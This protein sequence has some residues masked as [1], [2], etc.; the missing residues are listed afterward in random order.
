[1]KSTTKGWV[2]AISVGLLWGAEAALATL[3]LQIIDARLLVW[4]RYMMAF[5][6]LSLVLVLGAM[7]QHQCQMKPKLMFNWANRNDLFK[8]FV[9]GVFGQGL[10]SFLSFLSLDYIS[11]S[12]NGVIQGLVPIAILV[13]GQ[14]F[15]GACFTRIQIASSGIALIGVSILVLAPPLTSEDRGVNI[16]YLIC[17]LSVLSFAS[18]THLRAHLAE[19][20]GATRTMH[21][22]FGFAA[23]GF[24]IYLLASGLDVPGLLLVIQPSWPLLCIM[25]LGGVVSGLGYIAYIYGIERVGVEGSSMVLNLIPMSAFIIAVL[26]FGEPITPLRSMAVVLIIVAMMLFATSNRSR[27]T[28][29]KTVSTN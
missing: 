22:Q 10:F 2:A 12:E 9:C 15:Y 7:R 13:I 5:M 24:F 3:P 26:V 8:L 14:I 25:V 18:V 1:M 27:E 29:S 23:V 21:Y 28:T 19:K 17:L 4:L 11:L 20:Y 6:V 16:G